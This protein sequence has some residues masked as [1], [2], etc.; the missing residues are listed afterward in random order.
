MIGTTGT[1]KAHK[2]S[3]RYKEETFL[4]EFICDVTAGSRLAG[5]G[6]DLTYITPCICIAHSS[7]I[8]QK[9]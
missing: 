3:E 2:S 4:K 8:L 1:L 7:E 6:K 5:L 9:F